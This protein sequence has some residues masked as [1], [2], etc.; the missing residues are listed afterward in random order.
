MTNNA[1]DAFCWKPVSVSN[2]DHSFFQCSP[3]ND[4]SDTSPK[5]T[6]IG[7]KVF[8]IQPMERYARNDPANTLTCKTGIYNATPERIYPK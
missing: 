8:T 5:N 4:I 2:A 3:K 1:L 6:L 7:N